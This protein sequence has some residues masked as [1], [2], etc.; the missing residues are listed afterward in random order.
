MA[1]GKDLSLFRGKWLERL[2]SDS[3]LCFQLSDGAMSGGG[4]G[5]MGEEGGG[6]ASFSLVSAGGGKV[7]WL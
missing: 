3:L 6:G 4:E 2:G 7:R 1:M 5:P